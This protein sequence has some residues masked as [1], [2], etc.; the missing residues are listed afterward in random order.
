MSV[1]DRIANLNSSKAPLITPA[2]SS[3]PGDIGVNRIGSNSIENSRD[4]STSNSS[5]NAANI[6]HSMSGADSDGQRTTKPSTI[7]ERIARLKLGE[8]VKENADV[9]QWDRRER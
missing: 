7:A 1:R 3:G 8:V 2:G 9:R 5:E 6:T 4:T